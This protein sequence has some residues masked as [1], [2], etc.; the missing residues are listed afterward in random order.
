MGNRGRRE[1]VC[2]EELQ[3]HLLDLGKSVKFPLSAST[4]KIPLNP[5]LKSSP[6]HFMEIIII[7]SSYKIGLKNPAAIF[8]R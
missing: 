1:R 6:G 7:S 3:K 5:G 2:P 4:M 8:K